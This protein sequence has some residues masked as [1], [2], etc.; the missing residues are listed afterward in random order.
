ME[1][2]LVTAEPESVTIARSGAGDNG[3]VTLKRVE[4]AR[5]F[6]G[7]GAGDI[8]FNGRNSW[9]DI[10]KIKPL[11]GERLRVLT[12]DG[13]EYK[14]EAAVSDSDITIEGHKVPKARVL[15]V[16]YDRTRPRKKDGEH[17]EGKRFSRSIPALLYDG[18]VPENDLPAACKSR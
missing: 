15:R 7:T 17:A 6:D 12:K 13:S 4:V 16:F 10:G 9:S 14:G 5:V 1:G 8:V 2:Q 11:K 3:N 18:T